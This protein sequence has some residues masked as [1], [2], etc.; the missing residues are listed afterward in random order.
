MREHCGTCGKRYERL[1]WPR[2]CTRCNETAWLNPIP[3]V[4][5]LHPVIGPEASIQ[6]GGLP[7]HPV[8]A[9]V[10]KRAID[11]AKGAWGLISGYMDV[12]ETAEEA[13]RREFMEETSLE[14]EQEPRYLYSAHA[15]N[16]LMLFF[17]VDKP[18]SYAKFLTGTPCPENEELAVVWEGQELAFPVQSQFLAR[19]L[20]G[21]FNDD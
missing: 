11:P 2:T 5:V 7:V 13:A 20:N 16:Q 14:V 3:V 12:N 6:T 8:G 4:V 15:K 9:L 17:I 1:E 18:M 10:A 19:W 21:D